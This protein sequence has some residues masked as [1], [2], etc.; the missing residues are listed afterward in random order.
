MI[1]AIK[2]GPIDVVLFVCVICI[3][4]GMIFEAVGL[5]LIVPVFLPTLPDIKLGHIFKGVVSFAFADVIA[6]AL[7]IL[8]PVFAIGLVEL[9]R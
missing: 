8:F 2:L 4:L 5:L 7:I 3:I 9:L 1:G 6:L